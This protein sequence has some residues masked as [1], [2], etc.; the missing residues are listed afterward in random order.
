LYT[1]LSVL[2]KKRTKKKPPENAGKAWCAEE[3]QL[4]IEMYKSNASKKEMCYTLKR[5]ESSLAARLVRLGITENR[6]MFRYRK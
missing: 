4:L 6:D 3:E 2:D 5:T 1:I